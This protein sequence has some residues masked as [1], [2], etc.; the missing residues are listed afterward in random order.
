MP[1]HMLVSQVHDDASGVWE[2]LP[3]TRAH[4]VCDFI[5]RKHNE[6]NTSSETRAGQKVDWHKDS[7]P[8][9]RAVHPETTW[10]G[11]H[12]KVSMASLDSSTR[13]KIEV[14]KFKPGIQKER[15]T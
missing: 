3:E 1:Q 12:P 6:T 7:R 15:G 13:D 9:C 4:S 10:Q 8:H 2:K 11:V 14:Q 5:V